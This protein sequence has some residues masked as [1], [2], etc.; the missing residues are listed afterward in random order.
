MYKILNMVI[1]NSSVK[2]LDYNSTVCVGSLTGSNAQI[3]FRKNCSP[4]GMLDVIFLLDP[5]A[6]RRKQNWMGWWSM[7]LLYFPYI[8]MLLGRFSAI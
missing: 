7:I 5:G 1:L 6:Y 8:L 3:V 2:L 4:D